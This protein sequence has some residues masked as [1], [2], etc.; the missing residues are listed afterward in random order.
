MKAFDKLMI[1]KAY[2]NRAAWFKNGKKLTRDMIE[3]VIKLFT[4]LIYIDSEY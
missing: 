2:E 3:N 4:W 1:D